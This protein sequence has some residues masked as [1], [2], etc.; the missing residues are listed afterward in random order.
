[1]MKVAVLGAGAMGCLFGGRLKTAGIDVLLVDVWQAH[2]EQI[3]GRGLTIEQGNQK[4]TVKVPA[5]LPEDVGETPDLVLIFTK[6]HQTEAALLSISNV[7][8]DHTHILTLQNGVGHVDVIRQFVDISRII[9]G[10]T[11]YPCDVVGPGH[12]R[13]Q[14]S[15]E[16]KIMSVDH[17]HHELLI[18][19]ADMF[20]KAGFTCRIQP[21]VET[22]I[23]E[24]LAFNSALNALTAVLRVPIG[25]ISDT[26]QGRAL[27]FQIV[28]EVVAVAHKQNI[29]VDRKRICTT[30]EMAL[31]EHRDHQ[32]SML[33]DI[34]KNR[35][36]EIE[37]INGA[38][39]KTA[40]QLDMM[41]PVNE[42][43]Y[44]LLKILETVA[45][46]RGLDMCLSVEQF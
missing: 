18:A 20:S 42:T 35:K 10:V 5:A 24:K 44:G 38:V 21:D 28:D 30:V 29:A 9:H 33:Q 46:D 40:R 13:T 41:L 25:A 19:A 1:M 16:I 14:G 4:R 2:V 12:I 23:W 45:A 7:I 37:F 11:T 26:G 3:N 36:T 8:A 27:A 17:K 15:G 31:T 6:S 43:V 32:P 34:L 22:A 39:I